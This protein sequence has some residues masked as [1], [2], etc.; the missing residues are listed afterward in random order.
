MRRR[1]RDREKPTD[2][3]A[4][5]SLVLETAAN[6]PDFRDLCE[7]E[8]LIWMLEQSFMLGVRAA[9]AGA[10]RPEAHPDSRAKKERKAELRELGAD[11][12]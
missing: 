12:T 8:R 9:G 4:A 11:Q 1:K 10:T 6:T 3:R 7:A 2:P 5:A